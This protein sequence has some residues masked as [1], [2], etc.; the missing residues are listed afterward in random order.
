MEPAGLVNALIGMRAEEVALRLCARQWKEM[1]A[2][3][4]IAFFASASDPDCP[5][6]RYILGYNKE[7]TNADALKP[8][9]VSDML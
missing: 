8:H 2:L 7:R 1:S 5:S 6:V 3:C 4:G 9:K